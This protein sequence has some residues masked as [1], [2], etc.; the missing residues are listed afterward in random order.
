MQSSVAW[1]CIICCR[2]ESIS[3]SH[4][5]SETAL[6]QRKRLAAPRLREQ[7][8]NRAQWSWK[9][10]QF[11]QSDGN[12]E[13]SIVMLPESNLQGRERG[14]ERE[15]DRAKKRSRVTEGIVECKRR[16]REREWAITH[17]K[18]PGIGFVFMSR[19]LHIN[20]CKWRLW[21]Y[22]HR[23]SK[24]G[25]TGLLPEKEREKAMNIAEGKFSLSI[26]TV[27]NFQPENQPQMRHYTAHL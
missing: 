6:R 16:E 4:L 24:E 10:R 22:F 15:R 13:K 21:L 2:M 8:M 27:C 14:I 7:P 5:C 11:G 1:G 19:W 20:L 3:W 18:R 12:N 25:I 17:A 23:A 26:S 9:T